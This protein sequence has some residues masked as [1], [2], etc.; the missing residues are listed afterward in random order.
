M[1]LRA[2]LREEEKLGEEMIVNTI[3]GKGELR[4]SS[5]AFL[6]TTGILYCSIAGLLLGPAR[7]CG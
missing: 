4:L 1:S 7:E 3:V 2:V 5:P 6:S